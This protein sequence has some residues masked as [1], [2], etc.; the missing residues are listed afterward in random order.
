LAPAVMAGAAAESFSPAVADSLLE[1]E[2]SPPPA[3]T[4]STRKGTTGS[5]H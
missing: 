5:H 2:R 3:G 4:A 1:E